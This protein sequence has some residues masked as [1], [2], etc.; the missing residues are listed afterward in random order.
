[1]LIYDR[2]LLQNITLHWWRS[3]FFCRM[4][5]D[6]DQLADVHR[7]LSSSL[8]DVTAINS[9]A[10]FTIPHDIPRPSELSSASLILNSKLKHS[11][12]HSSHNYKHHQQRHHRTLHKT[13]HHHH[14]HDQTDIGVRRSHHYLAERLSLH[15]KAFSS[16]HLN[17]DQTNQHN[18]KEFTVFTDMNNNVMNSLLLP[19]GIHTKSKS[20]ENVFILSYKKVADWIPRRT[21]G[22]FE[23]VLIQI[24]YPRLLTFPGGCRLI[25]PLIT[26]LLDF[27][28]RL[29]FLH[30]FLE[31]FYCHHRAGLICF[32]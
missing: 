25:L 19:I 1:M 9:D 30:H 17:K 7:Q 16:E 27:S 32:Q 3:L 2:R 13:H 24:D 10:N 20:S 5:D 4:A 26:E 21:L 29:H 14:H 12:H 15:R 11:H 18:H 8:P 31:R 23:R 6:N 28:L 22:T